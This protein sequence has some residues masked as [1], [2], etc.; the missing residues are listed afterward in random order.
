MEKYSLILISV[1]LFSCPASIDS[2]CYRRLYTNHVNY[3]ITLEGR[4]PGGV[5]YALNNQN[6][7]LDVI[8]QEVN[9]LETCLNITINR[10]CFAVVISPF[11][12][13]SFG[14]EVFPC[15]IPI[16]VCE[17]KARAGLFPMESLCRTPLD[18]P[19]PEGTFRCGCRATIQD[20]FYI[21]TAPNL[22]LMKSELARLVTGINDIW[23]ESPPEIR[24]C[25]I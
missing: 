11:W 4:T 1:I 15:T 9:E 19:C 25:L 14:E 24:R 13:P 8:D 7:S 3:D 17:E 6:V 10:D 20:D 5:Q 12:T 16:S 21:V 2:Q 18:V 23:H 22:L